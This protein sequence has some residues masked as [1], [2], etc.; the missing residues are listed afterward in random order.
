MYHSTYLEV[1]LTK[2]SL[3]FRKRG[4]V[5]SSKCGLNFRAFSEIVKISALVS[6]DNYAFN[7]SL[8]RVL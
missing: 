6:I 3:N 4:D 8:V 7:H 5:K 2:K 1:L